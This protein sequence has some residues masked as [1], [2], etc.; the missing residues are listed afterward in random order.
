MMTDMEIM[1]DMSSI[2][3]WL[4]FAVAAAL[5]LYPS[6]RILS[7]LGFSPLWA[8]IIFVP[9]VN[10]VGLWMVALAAWPRCKGPTA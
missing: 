8:A 6:G 4:L 2:W 7:R 3:H 1:M 5:I 9:F 10:I